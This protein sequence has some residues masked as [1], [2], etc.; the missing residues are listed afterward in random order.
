MWERNLQFSCVR[1]C[2]VKLGTLSSC[3]G[4]VLK[5]AKCKAESR[6]ITK[7]GVLN[8]ISF[9]MIFKFQGYTLCGR[10]YRALRNSLRL[11]T[12]NTYI[13]SFSSKR[14]AMYCIVA[15]CGLISSKCVWFCLFQTRPKYF[16][17][18]TGFPDWWILVVY[19]FVDS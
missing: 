11:W 4:K 8:F 12:R 9:I 16:W 5:D 1:K 7:W 6:K 15:I 13:G 3:V 19:F 17:E 18:L 2:N 14:T 10:I